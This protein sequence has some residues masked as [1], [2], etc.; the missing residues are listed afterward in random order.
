[1]E[2]YKDKASFEEFLSRTMYHWI[3]NPFGMRCGRQPEM[4]GA[5][6]R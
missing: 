1:M 4:A 5:F 3:I 2:E 6:Y